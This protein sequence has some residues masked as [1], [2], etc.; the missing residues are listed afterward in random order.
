[1]QFS[2]KALLVLL[3]INTLLHKF[4]LMLK[5]KMAHAILKK[6]PQTLIALLVDKTQKNTFTNLFTLLEKTHSLLL[7]WT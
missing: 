2:F 4:L 5:M 7:L 3:V 6:H 1:M